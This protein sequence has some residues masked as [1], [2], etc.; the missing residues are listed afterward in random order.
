[1]QIIQ[2]IELKDLNLLKKLNVNFV[3][4]PSTKEIFNE[5]RVKKIVLPKNQKILCAK[6][7]KGHF[8]GV[9]DIMDRLIKLI[10]PRYTFMGE[11]DF[12]Q[13]FLVNKFIGKKYK[14]I[15]I[16]PCKTVKK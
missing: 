4:M 8:E 2:E 15:I 11:K 7:R 13:L 9:L 16:F 10:N 12:Q 6:F 14:N 3:F 1:M 5:K